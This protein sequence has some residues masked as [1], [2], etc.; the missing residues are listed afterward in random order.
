MLKGGSNGPVIQPGKNAASKL[1]ERV[2]STKRGFAMPPVGEPLSADQVAKLRAWIDQGAPVPAEA[3]TAD[4]GNP[5][6]RHWAFQP[7]T[8][9][10]PPEVRNRAWV[11]NPIDRFIADRKSVV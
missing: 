8:R 11:R 2:T 10:A 7:I 3:V 1:I 9:P 5:R 6:S 4:D